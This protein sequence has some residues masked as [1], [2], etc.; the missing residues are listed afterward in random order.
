MGSIFGSASTTTSTPT[1]VTA[2]TAGAQ[3]P[4]LIGTGKSTVQS[5]GGG[6]QYI[7]TGS[8][9]EVIL[10]TGDL[11]TSSTNSGSPNASAAPP[12]TTLGD[13][14]ADSEA[15]L[16][17]LLESGN[18]GITTTLAPETNG[19]PSTLE[20]LAGSVSTTTWIII[21]IVAAT[22]LFLFLKKK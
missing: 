3:S 2:T 9:A 8:K 4:T 15:L 17:S 19:S 12:A 16:D 22:V 7:L 10:N 14:G 20:N 1:E 18:S 11:G 5:S 13:S 6:A 21:G